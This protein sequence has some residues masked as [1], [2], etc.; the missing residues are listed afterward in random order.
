M[1]HGRYTILES[2]D[3][4]VGGHSPRRLALHSRILL[5]VAVVHIEIDGTTKPRAIEE[6]LLVTGA[7][8]VVKPDRHCP[9]AKRRS[10][11]RNGA[12]W[13]VP[14]L[15]TNDLCIRSIPKVVT[16]R[17]PL[18]RGSWGCGPGWGV[19]KHLD[20]PGVLVGTP[21][22][23]NVAVVVDFTRCHRLEEDG[24]WGAHALA[25]TRV[26]DAIA[27]SREALDV[28]KARCVPVFVMLHE[29]PSLTHIMIYIK[30]PS[31]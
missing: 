19:D 20:P 10:L 21:D 5:V 12:C 18:R 29:T 16:N 26:R 9:L 1:G 15:A 8:D 31:Y 3:K 13:V 27:V 11:E 4:V 14:E 6:T 23:A 22:E 17:H 28:G 7:R 24:G 30:R 2:D 25:R